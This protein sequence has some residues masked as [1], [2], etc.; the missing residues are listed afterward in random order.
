MLDRH[1]SA[2]NVDFIEAKIKETG[3]GRVNVAAFN[4]GVI[5]LDPKLPKDYEVD[6]GQPRAKARLLSFLNPARYG[7]CVEAPEWK[8]L[9]AAAD[10]TGGGTDIDKA[11]EYAVKVLQAR[12][13][14]VTPMGRG[15]QQLWVLTDGDNNRRSLDQLNKLISEFQQLRASY[16]FEYHE[17]V[18]LEESQLASHAK[19]RHQ[20]LRA[21]GFNVHYLPQTSLLSVRVA[22]PPPTFASGLHAEVLEAE[23]KLPCDGA[24][25]KPLET[26]LPALLFAAC[27]QGHLAPG[28]F[29]LRLTP[30]SAAA[31]KATALLGPEI[32]ENSQIGNPV[33]LALKLS[34][35][36]AEFYT[37]KP[38]VLE[39][40]LGYEF[41]AQNTGKVAPVVD[42]LGAKSLV[43]RVRCVPMPPFE[44]QVAGTMPALEPAKLEAAPLHREDISPGETIAA[45]EVRAPQLQ[46]DLALEAH[47]E[48]IP[49]GAL[50][51]ADGAS[52][53]FK[54]SPSQ[55]QHS[56]CIVATGANLETAQGVLHVR[57]KNPGPCPARITAGTIR[58][59]IF[60]RQ[61]VDLRW[62]SARQTPG[63]PPNKLR[64]TAFRDEGNRNWEFQFRADEQGAPGTEFELVLPGTPA[65]TNGCRVS[66]EAGGSF[67]DIRRAISLKLAGASTD[68][69]AA[70]ALLLDSP[71]TNHVSLA[72][73]GEAGAR[74]YSGTL[75]VVPQGKFEINQQPQMEIPISVN[76]TGRDGR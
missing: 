63:L 57:E 10:R 73:R 18:F 1:L 47:L 14:A 28:R 19:R 3:S 15:I 12:P 50:A 60:Y 46:A 22:V 67:T 41:E 30:A 59:D 69:P 65:Y 20:L 25:A 24:I 62:F 37:G 61:N 43:V 48:S 68:T 76:L 66:L 16:G 75:K 8:G 56:I 5:Q 29:H 55:K 39:W 58:F 45:L 33:S 6:L 71:G 40:Q 21:A 51:L 9:L 13:P 27:K 26:R 64:L 72:L 32:I 11:L 52:S 7:P 35:V 54:L 38:K 4:E 31:A 17:V 42:Y 44:I 34:H 23:L 53:N 49:P 36:P 70:D 2:P 74:L